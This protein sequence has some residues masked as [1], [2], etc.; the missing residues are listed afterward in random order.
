MKL[1]ANQLRA[2]AAALRAQGKLADA[3]S[4]Y[5][6][7]EALEP[8]DRV[9]LHNFAAAL[10]DVGRWREAE[11]VLRRAMGAGLDAAETWLVWARCLQALGRLDEA[12]AA[13]ASAL[14]RKPLTDARRELA[15]LRWMRTGNA[16]HALRDIDA[17]ISRHPADASLRMMKAHLLEQ[18]GSATEASAILF[19][20]V[21]MHPASAPIL[22]A[23]AQASIK[24]GRRS[25]ALDLARR[26]ATL[27]PSEQVVLVTLAEAALSAGEAVEAL[28]AAERMLSA[29][30]D[31][32][33]ALAF[34]ATAWRA[35]GDPRYREAYDYERFVSARMIHTPQGWSDLSGYLADLTAAV[36]DA[37]LFSAHPFAQSLRNGGQAS[38]LL[39][40]PA[41]PIQ[42]LPE[43]LDP[44]IRDYIAALGHGDDPLRRRNFGGYAFQGMW[45]VQLRP[46]GFHVDHVHPK[47]WISSACYLETVD[48]PDREGWIKFG[49]PGSPTDPSMAAE[50]FVEPRPGMLVLFPSYMWHG[51]VPFSG[52]RKRLT[53]AFDLT[54]APA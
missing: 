14:A 33:H 23:A 1:S 12:E 11:P 30:P 44:P 9:S 6:R 26:A 19:S 5:I 47:G 29:W 10:G 21:A 24:L 2:E 39:D 37:H 8:G 7:A 40:N 35:L 16:G 41:P 28:E 4:L 36:R 13:F 38:E 49:E 15:Q 48:R 34:Q 27:A 32:Q 42:A 52:E 54:P 51:T 25:Q 45:S 31:N 20:L 3:I 18:M 53:F 22:T 50:H 46:G 43:A 17:A